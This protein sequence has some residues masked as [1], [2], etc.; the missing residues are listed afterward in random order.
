VKTGPEAVLMRISSPNNHLKKFVKSF[1][2]T[3]TD[4]EEIDLSI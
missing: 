1:E 4:S 3:Y 2:I